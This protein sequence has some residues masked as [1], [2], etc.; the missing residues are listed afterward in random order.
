[1]LSW[2]F[3]FGKRGEGQR[4]LYWLS[5]NDRKSY[6]LWLSWTPKWLEGTQNTSK[7]TLAQGGKA[8]PA[9]F[10]SMLLL[11]SCSLPSC[12]ALT[13]SGCPPEGREL[14]LEMETDA[15]PHTGR[16]ALETIKHMAIMAGLDRVHSLTVL[17]THHHEGLIP[18]IT[19]P[20]WREFMLITPTGTGHRAFLSILLGDAA[21]ISNFSFASCFQTRSEFFAF[22][23]S[24]SV[25]FNCINP[26]FHLLLLNGYRRRRNAGRATQKQKAGELWRKRGLGKG[27]KGA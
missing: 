19:G 6:S 3:F 8:K 24:Y 21:F 15:L 9:P 26:A 25:N 10:S 4:E 5:N 13:H 2:S 23:H 14:H 12:C 27:Q 18:I 17:D 11:C 16:Q 20:S 7:E 1:M 22:S